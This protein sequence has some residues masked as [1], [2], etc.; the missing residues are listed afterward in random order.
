M[1]KSHY[2]GIGISLFLIAGSAFYI[3]AVEAGFRAHLAKDYTGA[4]AGLKARAAN[5]DGFATYLLGEN[6][7]RQH[8]P[9][10]SKEEA[11]EWYEK[12]L[13]LGSLHSAAGYL[14]AFAVSSK[15]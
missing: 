3:R 15:P 13:E 8:L 4:E 12:G 10:A 6:R 11:F 14:Y 2:T 5:G 7:Y 1:K 9:G